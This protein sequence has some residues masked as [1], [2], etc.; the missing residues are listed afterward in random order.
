VDHLTSAQIGELRARL[1]EERA[2]LDGRSLVEPRSGTE[3]IEVGDSQDRAVEEAIRGDEVATLE[4]RTRRIAAIDRALVRMEAGTY[5]VCEDTGDPIPYAR[6][7]SDP[8]ARYTVDAQ[9]AR[10]GLARPPDETPG[11]Y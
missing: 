3:P 7:L 1:V 6:L 8:T 5:G 11:G 2:R 10:E 9:E 4:R